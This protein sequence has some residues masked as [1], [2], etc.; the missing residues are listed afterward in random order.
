MKPSRARL[1]GL[2]VVLVLDLAGVTTIGIIALTVMSGATDATQRVDGVMV[3]AC[4]GVGA[5]AWLLAVVAVAAASAGVRP[6]AA[7]R[8]VWVGL[9]LN[10]IG[11]VV[12]A[13]TAAVVV[14]PGVGDG[15]DTVSAGL[16]VAL[17]LGVFGAVVSLAYLLLLRTR[18]EA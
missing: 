15:L 6:R 10:T 13:I 14:G 11:S 1:T 16:V 17:T 2:L 7:R 9:V 18:S 4:A 12:V 5:G 8:W 3:A